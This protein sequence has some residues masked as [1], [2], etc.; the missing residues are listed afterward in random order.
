MSARRTQAEQDHAGSIRPL[1]RWTSQTRQPRI[2]LPRRDR[3]VHRR[4]ER[5]AVRTTEPPG[6]KSGHSR[7]RGSR[8]NLQQ[9]MGTV[10]SPSIALWLTTAR[11]TEG[12]LA[13]D[14][15]LAAVRFG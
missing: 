14:Y 15:D 4:H 8:A 1:G 13:P 3:R 12:N 10:T 2:P 5:Y 11:D 9:S 6:P 7:R